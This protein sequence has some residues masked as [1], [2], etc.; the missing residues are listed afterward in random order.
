V[1]ETPA[2]RPV[3]PKGKGGDRLFFDFNQSPREL[4]RVM[5]EAKEKQRAYRSQSGWRKLLA[6]LMFPLGLVFFILDVALGYNICTFTLVALTLWAGGLFLLIRLGRQKQVVFGTRY[7]IVRQIFGV[8]KDDMSPGRTMMGWLD[9]TG[10]E[11]ES[12][13]VRQKNSPSG[14]PVV[15]YQD[16]WLRLKARLYDG[17][18]LRVSLVQRLKVRKGYYKRGRISGKRKWKPGSSQGRYEMKMAVSADSSTF[19]IQPLAQAE[20]VP[21]SRFV[22]QE[23]QRG[24]GRLTVKATVPEGFDAWDVLNAMQFVYNHIQPRQAAV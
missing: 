16:E 9:L 13:I 12:K 20:P 15:Y 6:V 1:P 2:H 10:A 24:P 17:N 14:R 21:N 3:P 8:L 7:D 19:D 23:T 11:Q 22:I 4:V 5:D 18:V